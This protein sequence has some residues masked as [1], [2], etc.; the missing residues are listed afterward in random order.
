[1]KRRKLFSLALA[2]VLALS[3][4]GC[5]NQHPE[6]TGSTADGGSLRLIATSPAVAE[7]CG[8]LDLDLV[9]VCETSS[10]LPEQYAALPTV[11]M[12]M[13][14][15]LEI[16]KSLNPDYVLSPSTLQNDL[17]PKYAAAGVPS[18]FLNLRSVEGMYASISDLGEKFGRQ[19][20]AQ[21]LVDEYN[22]FMKE[23]RSKNEGKGSPRVLVLMG[24]P[25]SYIVAT[26][27]SYVGSLVKLAGG[28]NVYGD[29]DGQEFLFANTEDMKLKDA[30]VIVRAAHGLPDQA[31]EMFA[32][33]FATNDIWQH[34]TAVK[35][36]RVYDLDSSLFNMSANFRYEEALEQLQPMLYG[37]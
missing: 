19:E 17:Q 2:G 3:V 25:G 13:N 12:P 16:I 36:G 8:R 32:E 28:T 35:E 33:E 21:A 4:T 27:S 11:G 15:D 29:G 7:I 6:N 34:F 5:V 23:Y 22:A 10:E 9:G 30:D 31:R 14:P 26:D 18:L 37:G 1:M 20:E 24:L